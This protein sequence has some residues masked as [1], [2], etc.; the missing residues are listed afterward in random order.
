MRE[1][2]LGVIK[3]QKAKQFEI[4]GFIMENHS[5]TGQPCIK[6]YPQTKQGLSYFYAKRKILSDGVSTTHLDI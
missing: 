6:T 2:F 1:D 4:T 3:T 5:I